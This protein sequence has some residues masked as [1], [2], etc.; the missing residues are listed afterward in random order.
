MIY[1]PPPASWCTQEFAF[2][3]ALDEV[4]SDGRTQ[5]VRMS[6]AAVT[7]V[8]FAHSS[9]RAA[10][11]LQGSAHLN[12]STWITPG[13]VTSSLLRSNSRSY[14]RV[15]KQCTVHLLGTCGQPRAAPARTTGRAASPHRS[16]HAARA[17]RPR[18]P[19]GGVTPRGVAAWR[20][21]FSPRGVVLRPRRE[22][23]AGRPRGLRAG[24][25]P[26]G[27]TYAPAPHTQPRFLA[28]SRKVPLT[29]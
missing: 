14:C 13:T 19:R 28:Q 17:G 2:R 4:M 8:R 20:D 5:M 6:A 25:L 21:D 23:R 15:S 26:L 3:G 9:A 16:S 11:R 1:E 18:G 24:N 12:E 10:K 7:S 27:A 29:A 22:W